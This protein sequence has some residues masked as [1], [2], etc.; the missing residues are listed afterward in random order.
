MSS[1]AACTA[2][3]FFVFCF[4]HVSRV[5]EKGQQPFLSRGPSGMPDD[6]PRQ[7]RLLTPFLRAAYFAFTSKQY[8]C[9]S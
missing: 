4:E 6:L 1:R 8:R 2:F 9:V 3:F 7:K 5:Q